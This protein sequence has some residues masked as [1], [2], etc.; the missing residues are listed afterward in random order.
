MSSISKKYPFWSIYYED[1][2]FSITGDRIMGRQAAGWSYLKAL[3]KD[4][5]SK[6]SAYIRKDDQK[7][8]QLGIDLL[9]RLVDQPVFL[10]LDK[11]FPGYF[12]SIEGV[13]HYSFKGPHPAGN[14]SLHIQK[15]CPLNMND[16]V[17]TCL[18]YTSPSPRDS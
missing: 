7:E 17:W 12:E 14:L 16:R 4:K 9:N 2:G 1:E 18:L 8:F 6:L 11:S 3:I 13:Q 10:G 15:L 5:P